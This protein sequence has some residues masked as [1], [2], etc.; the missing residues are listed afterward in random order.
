MRARRSRRSVKPTPLPRLTGEDILR[1]YIDLNASDSRGEARSGILADYLF[2]LRGEN[3]RVTT[4][5]L[6]A[7]NASWRP[8]ALPAVA[9]VKNETDIEGSLVIGPT[10]NRTRMVFA[11]TDWSGIGDLTSPANATVQAPVPVASSSPPTIN[12]PEF[13]E[14]AIP[15]VGTLLI[16]LVL[17]RRR[18]RS[19]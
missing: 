2:E 5:A 16:I 14:I 4:R 8:V 18:R 7:W 13:H 1:V 15:V 12:A 17:V 19:D 10:T 3:G 6:F 9:L 11:A